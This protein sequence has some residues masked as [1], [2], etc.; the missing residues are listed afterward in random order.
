M[1]GSRGMG[2]WGNRLG[3]LGAGGE[4]ESKKELS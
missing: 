3:G 4:G 2:T 1:V